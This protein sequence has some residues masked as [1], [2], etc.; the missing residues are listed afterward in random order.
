V[1]GG[2]RSEDEAVCGDVDQSG[3]VE[4]CNGIEDVLAATDVAD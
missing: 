4:V 2:P 1:D 3:A